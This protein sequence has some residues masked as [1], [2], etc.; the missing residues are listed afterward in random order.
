MAHPLPADNARTEEGPP[1]LRRIAPLLLILPLVAG[2]AGTAKLTQKSQER[3]AS[4]DHWKAWQFATRALDK[5]PGNPA[6]RRA[7]TAAGASIADEW[8]RPIH[9][10]PALDS[11]KAAQAL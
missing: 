7:A 5:E 9:A 1:M 6:A 2:C 8:L 10:T 11:I 3:L 4:G